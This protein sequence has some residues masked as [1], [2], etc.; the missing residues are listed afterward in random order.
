MPYFHQHENKY[1]NK[2]PASFYWAA[3]SHRQCHIVSAQECIVYLLGVFP[4]EQCLFDSQN[5]QISIFECNTF[6]F[7][8][9]MEKIHSTSSSACSISNRGW[10]P[11]EKNVAFL[12]REPRDFW[13]IKWWNNQHVKSWANMQMY[14]KFRNG[15]PGCVWSARWVATKTVT[16]FF[17]LCW[18]K[19][20]AH[21][22]VCECTQNFESKS[23]PS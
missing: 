21:A 2:T 9:E 3:S 19:R 5:K 7:F 14:V 4:Y 15:W 10:K 13:E 8:A 22:I 20:A 17:R 1:N 12:S 11:N 16:Q 23:T 18:D 6:E